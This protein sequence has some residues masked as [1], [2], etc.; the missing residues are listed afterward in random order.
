MKNLTALVAILI[1]F[2]C[3]S[4]NRYLL[5]DKDKKDKKFLFTTIKEA[6]A[7]GEISSIKP[8]IVIDGKPLRYDIELKEHNLPF[9]KSEIKEINILKRDVGIRIYGDFAEGGVLVITTKDDT[10]EEKTFENSNIL[11]LVDGVEVSKEDAEAINPNNIE[12]VNIL[13]G[14]ASKKL[15]PNENYDGVIQIHMKKN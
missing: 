1:L 3:C 10:I 5:T 6:K 2:S 8:I 12:T 14:E 4:S 13:K 11:F 9:S 15:Y 7:K